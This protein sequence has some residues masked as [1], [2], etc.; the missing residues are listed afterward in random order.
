[1]LNSPL[2]HTNSPQQRTIV[3]LLEEAVRTGNS[4]PAFRYREGRV[5][6]EVNPMGPSQVLQ[7]ARQWATVSWREYG[8]LVAQLATSFRRWGIETGDR[9]AILSGNRWEWHVADMALLTVGAVSVPVYPTSA[10]E[11]I[12]YILEHSA[13]SMCIVGGSDQLAK[14]ATAVH[15]HPQLTT[16]LRRVIVMDD[17]SIQGNVPFA[18]DPSLAVVGWQEALDLGAPSTSNQSDGRHVD[19]SVGD[20][21]NELDPEGLATLVYTSGTTGPPKGV[22]LTHRNIIETVRMVRAV[23]PLG[24]TDRFLSFL[25]LSHIAE[26]VVSHFGQIASAGE[27]WFAQ[28]FSTVSKDILDCRPTVFFAVPRVWE[29]IR[30]TFDIKAHDL[31]PLRRALVHRFQRSHA[32]VTGR[33]LSFDSVRR[34]EHRVLDLAI[35]RSIRFAI[36][37]DR[38]RALYSGAAPIDPELLR[39]LRTIGLD[40]GEVYGQTEVCGPTSV[41]DPNSIRIG[42]VG[43]PLPGMQVKLTADYEI[44]VKGPN[45]CAGYFRNQDA[46]SQLFDSDGWMRTGDL[47]SLDNEGFLRISGRKKDLMK[48]ALGKYVAP[49]ELELRLRS[50]R[51]IANAVVVAEGRPFISALLTLDAEAIGPWAQHRDKPLSIEALS[52]DPD[53]LAEV[54]REVDEVN[55]TLSPPERV[56]KWR[57]LSRDLTVD[58]GEI[59]PTL[60]VVRKVVMEHFADDMEALYATGEAYEAQ[61]T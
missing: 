4:R 29:K 3:D 43:R 5:V 55:E 9:V 38:A 25:P 52:T 11:Q 22:M 16:A 33:P 46:T 44:L 7:R 27:T 18:A 41:T 54:S 20:P 10:A 1:V 28:S 14:L 2:P 17:K 58:D 6:N 12:G 36:G 48:T 42:T 8:A 35:G 32:E 39:W 23:V 57:V 47:G 34:I 59:T 49:Q 45:V 13:S 30:E 24:P 37:L 26:R 56:R 15:L 40:V 50:A 61:R 53:V 21:L 51:F 19:R 60:K 31:D